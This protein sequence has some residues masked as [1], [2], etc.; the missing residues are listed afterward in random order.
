MKK[1]SEIEVGNYVQF[2][3]MD[4]L[5]SIMKQDA[6]VLSW[7]A[8]DFVN[9]R[10]IFLKFQVKGHLFRGLVMIGVN[11]LDLFEVFLVDSQGTITCEMLNIYI[12]ELI[13]SIDERV[14]KISNYKW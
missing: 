4:G 12:D 7:G 10:N 6:K 9:D 5:I 14:E 2:C 1:L 3:D 13:D 11:G 8:H